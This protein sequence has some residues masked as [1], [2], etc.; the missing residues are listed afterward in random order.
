MA[1]SQWLPWW[2]Y[3]LEFV[4][5][6]ILQYSLGKSLWDPADLLHDNLPSP[7]DHP[8]LSIPYKYLHPWQNSTTKLPNMLSFPSKS[9]TYLVELSLLNSRALHNFVP[10]FPSPSY[11]SLIPACCCCLCCTSPCFY[12]IPVAWNNLLIKMQ[13]AVSSSFNKP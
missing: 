4:T 12:T 9:C 8:G 11:P 10:G 5:Q 13:Q 2:S 6:N 7:V 1:K 3:A